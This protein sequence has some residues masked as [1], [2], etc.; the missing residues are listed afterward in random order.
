MGLREWIQGLRKREDDSAIRRAQEMSEDS[1][2]ERSEESEGIENI[3]ADA[4]AY[5]HGG[6]PP[7][8]PPA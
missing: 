6:E 3:A 4:S 7:A 1:P 5:E 8:D 2:Q